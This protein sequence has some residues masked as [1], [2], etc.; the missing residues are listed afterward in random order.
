M[1]HFNSLSRIISGYPFYYIFL[2]MAYHKSCKI[3][4]SFI[5]FFIIFYAL[6][7]IGL[8]VNYFYVI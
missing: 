6:V 5:R 1:I 4:K 8:G 2:A 3:L 7:T